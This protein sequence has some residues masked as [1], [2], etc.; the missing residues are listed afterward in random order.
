MY[1]Q[2][3]RDGLEN[4]IISGGSRH[5][6]EASFSIKRIAFVMSRVLWIKELPLASGGKVMIP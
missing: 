4:R 2:S 6:N 3:E 5:E 1:G